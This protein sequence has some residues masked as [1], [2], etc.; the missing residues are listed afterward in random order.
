MRVRK[1]LP[2]CVSVQG[3]TA[4]SLERA[5]DAAPDVSRC[6]CNVGVVGGMEEENAREG[7]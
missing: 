5:Q 3:M 4:L 6:G 2:S 1:S 7:E